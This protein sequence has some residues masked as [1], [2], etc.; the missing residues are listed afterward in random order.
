MARTGR[1]CFKPMA[2]RIT[3]RNR[4]TIRERL[5]RA[6]SRRDSGADMYMVG[7]Y[8]PAVYPAKR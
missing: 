5:L 3:R 1:Y 4:M 8:Y 2:G 6:L 7:N